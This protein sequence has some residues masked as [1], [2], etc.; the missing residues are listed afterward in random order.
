MNNFQ[1][2]L[3]EQERQ[4]EGETKRKVQQGLMQSFGTFRLIGQLIGVYLPAMAN[5]VVTAFG[6][7]C[8]SP[9]KP[10]PPINLPPSLGDSNPGKA[11]PALPPD[12]DLLR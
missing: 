2:L 7:Q 6:G 5:V 10:A 9:K 3:E 4:F 11:G 12:L 8:G 1:Q